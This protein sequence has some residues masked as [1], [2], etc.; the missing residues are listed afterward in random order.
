[1]TR[2]TVAR[3]IPDSDRRAQ[4]D[5]LSAR[6]TPAAY[7]AFIIDA[8]SS[9]QG[10]WQEA[11]SIQARMIEEATRYGS[12]GMRI[13]HFGGTTLAAYPKGWTTSAKQISDYM[14]KINCV[15][16]GTQIIGA[17]RLA[18]DASPPPTLIVVIGDAFEEKESDLTYTLRTGP[19]Q[20]IAI[21]AFLEGQDFLAENAFRMIAAVT[22]GVFAR[23]GDTLDLSSLMVATAA[24]A[25]GG[26]TALLKL[27]N[28]TTTKA[29]A[30]AQLLKLLP[31]PRP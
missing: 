25:A 3:L 16:G 6:S 26:A 9:R 12:L 2:N 28:G 30:A 10:A 5:C 22:G 31:A 18:L 11:I 8:T 14:R 7:V 15:A 23:F 24:Y 19:I 21:F 27:S 29:Q 13:V 20:S 17:I 1:M 4:L